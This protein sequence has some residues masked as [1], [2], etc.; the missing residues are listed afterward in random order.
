MAANSLY[1][2]INTSDVLDKELIKK[3][4]MVAPILGTKYISG[5]R[6]I[7]P[8]VAN[9]YRHDL[10]GIFL[11]VLMIPEPFIYPHIRANGYDAS[12]S[13]DSKRLRLLILDPSALANY[14]SLFTR[15]N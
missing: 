13:Y 10:H 2:T 9:M 5:V 15:N 1:K 11:T 12:H 3:W 6:E 7:T 14:Y 4:N 8:H